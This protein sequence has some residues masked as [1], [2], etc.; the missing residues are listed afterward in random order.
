MSRLHRALTVFC[1][2]RLLD[3]LTTQYGLTRGFTEANPYVNVGLG[4]PLVTL[5]FLTY[6]FYLPTL[7]VYNSLLYSISI[8]VWAAVA[9]NLWV[10]TGHEALPMLESTLCLFVGSLLVLFFNKIN[11]DFNSDII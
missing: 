5:I 6:D 9:N 8:T 7:R 3:E 10:L 11:I 4:M 2:G 1:L